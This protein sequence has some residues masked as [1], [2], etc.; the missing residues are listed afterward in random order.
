MAS[1]TTTDPEGPAG[2]AVV[3]PHHAD[4]G[5]LARCLDALAAQDRSGVEVVVVDNDSP[6]GPPDLSAWPF[7]RLVVERARGAAAARNRGVAETA[8]PLLLFLDADCVPRP[9]W[10]AAARAAAPRAG[11]VGGHV[12]VFDETPPPRSGAEAFETVFAF[13]VA[14]YVG[15]KGFA[16]T[17]NLLTTR[18]AFE[19][20]G[21][22]RAGL[23]EDLDWC[24][25]ATG[26][27]HRL[28][29]E[30]AMSVLHPTRSDWP[31]LRRKWR[32]LTDEGWGLHRAE[33]AGLDPADPG[34]AAAPA[35]AGARLSWAGRALLMPASIPL[36]LPRLLRS[37]RLE[38][39]G[40]A[41][42]GALT[43]VRLRLARMAWMLGQAL[44]P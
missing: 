18:A 10:L 39:P 9:G 3:V 13:D 27:G 28:T 31:A 2:I 5:R 11:R 17:A 43:L 7:A 30:P 6:G 25:R 33:R 14:R 41:R 23:S 34:A 1:T 40:E 44:R 24:R 38:R 22:F 16:V 37:P 35:G 29:Y 8:A 32:R 19:A 12:G 4:P 15:A 42:R 26:L 36:H 21:G 20:T